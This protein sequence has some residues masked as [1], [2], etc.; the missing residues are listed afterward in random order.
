M[1]RL[2]VNIDHVATVRQARRT[3]EPDPVWAA[4]D[5]LDG[6]Y[7]LLE[8]LAR[9]KADSAMPASAL[10]QWAGD[11]L[12]PDSNV[13][14]LTAA[15]DSQLSAV[16]TALRR[17]NLAVAVVVLDAHS[18]DPKAY[19]APMTDLLEA[20]GAT[21]LPLDRKADLREVLSDVLAA[22]D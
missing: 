15:P 18:F 13:V 5:R 6:E 1:P 20:A 14:L 12:S 11:R 17:R 10:L 21:V 9:V 8:V 7:E 3:Y 19:P 22:S 16:I 2:G 4:A